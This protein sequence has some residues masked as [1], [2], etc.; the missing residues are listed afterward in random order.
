MFS[1][2]KHPQLTISTINNGFNFLAGHIT[3]KK[4]KKNSKESC[5][6]DIMFN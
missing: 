1:L 2:R 5:H 3:K 6:V 4:E